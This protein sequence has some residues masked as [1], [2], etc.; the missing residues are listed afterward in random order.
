ME[1]PDLVRKQLRPAVPKPDTP[2]PLAK[3]GS[4]GGS[5]AAAA[6]GSIQEH[7]AGAEGGDDISDAAAAAVLASSSGEGKSEGLGR[8]GGE[9]EDLDD[10][11]TDEAKDGEWAGEG[12]RIPPR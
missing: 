12:R 2:R 9:E 4:K 8:E 1:S 5:A 10:N 11:E 3:A 6:S 7:P